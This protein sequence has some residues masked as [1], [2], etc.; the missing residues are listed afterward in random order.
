MK[1]VRSGFAL[2]G[3]AAGLASLALG[4]DAPPA[5]P[6]DRDT[7]PTVAEVLLWPECDEYISQPHCRVTVN[8]GANREPQQ[9]NHAELMPHAHWD[10]QVQPFERSKPLK[11]VIPM[12]KAAAILL[13]RSSPFLKCTVAAVPGAPARDLSTN[14][15]T[16]L[17]AFA[18]IGAPPPVA[19]KFAPKTQTELFAD[20]VA[21]GPSGT[22]AGLEAEIKA[23]ARIIADPY[24]DFRK[25]LKEDWKYTFD[26]QDDA[27]TAIKDLK[28]AAEKALAIPPP[29]FVALKPQV[30][31]LRVRLAAYALTAPPE[32]ARIAHDR[33][34]LDGLLADVEA[35]KET[36]ADLQSKRKSIRGV[37]DFLFGLLNPPSPYTQAVLPMSYFSAKT[38][39]E[40]ITC[41]DASSKDQVFDNTVFVAYYEALPHF[42]ISAGAIASLLGGRQVAELSGPYT[43]AQQAVCAAQT[44][45]ATGTAPTCGPATVLGYSTRSHYQFMPGVFAEWRVKNFRRP[46]AENGSPY[47]PLG[48]L[49]SIGLAG[50]VAINPNNGGPAAEFFTGVSLGLQ[51]FALMIGAHAGR[52]QEFGGGYYAGE[53]FPAGTTVTPPTAYNWAWHPAF[54]IAYRVPIR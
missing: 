22:L 21:P 29:D 49:W 38:V 39:T 23:F 6:V 51:R 48:Y 36:M 8:I 54:A 47:H 44:P 42:E 25:A 15:G 45:P 50:G 26:S 24:A 41:K 35:P 11:R 10:V 16:L 31:D 53:M 9:N 1:R 18:G 43:P 28:I 19:D 12:G 33:L 2:I 7:P 32:S 3:M 46:G 34:V 17:T 37:Y 14:I 27:D 13:D 30:L 40:T 52:Y 5:A 4:Q 20:N